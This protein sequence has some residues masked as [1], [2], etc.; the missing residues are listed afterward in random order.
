MAWNP[1]VD[2]SR[3]NAALGMLGRMGL[4]LDSFW[5]ALAYC[6]H[7]RVI[8]WSLFPLL[9]MSIMIWALGYFFWADA[10]L[11]VQGLLDGVGWLHS[12]W[13]WMQNHGVGYASEVVASV[14]VVLGVTPV[15]VVISLLLVAMFMTPALTELVAQRRFP[16]M[17]KKQGGSTIASAL[18]S[19]GSTGI[20]LIALLVTMPLWFMPPLMLVITP[21]IWGW[22]T[23]RVMAF[24]VLA[25]HASKLERRSVFA[26]N[27][28]ALILMGVICGFL[29]AAPGVVWASGLIFIAAFWILI[30]IAIWM[31]ALVFAFS[32]LWFAHFCLAALQRMREQQPQPPE[33]PQVPFAPEAGQLPA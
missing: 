33:E 20:A 4:L 18:W 23:Y 5:R 17:E 9:L 3:I 21:L 6:L 7:K 25:T 11:R 16:L 32:S 26:Q 14:L 30:P 2:G 29:G 13:M 12:L 8:A 19:L 27:R 31:Y 15:V 22:L 1:T 28:I 24:D 10:V